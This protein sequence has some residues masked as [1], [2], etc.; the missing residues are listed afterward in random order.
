[1]T[2][3]S[4]VGAIRAGVVSVG[5]EGR[6]LGEFV[7]D[8]KSRDVTVLADVRLN[9]VSRRKG[10]SKT[11]LRQALEAA[12]IAYVHLRGLGNPR[13]NRDAFA[14]DDVVAAQAKFRSLLKAEAGMNDLATLRELASESVVAVLCVERIEANCHR[15]VV[16]DAL[17]SC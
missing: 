7:R 15:K 3:L 11:A 10:F 5:Y 4:G 14:S 9:A 1:M 6:E 17:F 16:I 12:G 13:E 8:L 2:T